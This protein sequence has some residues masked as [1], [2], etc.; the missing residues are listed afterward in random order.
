MP[1]L[2]EYCVNEE[3]PTLGLCKRHVKVWHKA[4]EPVGDAL[5]AWVKA[6]IDIELDVCLTP[7]ELALEICDR[8]DRM[9]DFVPT[10]GPRILEPSAG[11]G[12]FVRAA[13]ATWPAAD[14]W[15]AEIREE[16]KAVLRAAG[17][18]VVDN[19]DLLTISGFVATD[20]IIGNPPFAVA[21]QHIRHL[22]DNMKEG[23]HLAFL[24][25]LGFYESKERLDFWETYPE[26]YFIP[27]VPRPG[28]KLNGEGK[29]GTDSQAYGL[30]IWQKGWTG[31]STRLPHLVWKKARAK[32]QLEIPT[33]A[34]VLVTAA[35]ELDTV[36]PP[37]L[38][39]LDEI[40]FEEAPELETL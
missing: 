32:K 36:E 34:S 3:T 15:A 5:N 1:C 17:A 4:G 7:P 31:P 38:E 26:K 23:A 13:R 33:S 14:I 8:I 22:L 30:F 35:P 21:E 11:D 9:I 10:M 37:E 20:L 27:I 19:C 12:A 2:V 18:T 29:Q 40:L 39:T 6:Q 16:C 28:F 25:R 24:L